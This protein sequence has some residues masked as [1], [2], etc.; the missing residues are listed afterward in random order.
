MK[1]EG[2]PSPAKKK[3]DFFVIILM[4]EPWKRGAKIHALSVVFAEA[5]WVEG[6]C[7]ESSSDSFDSSSSDS[8]PLSLSGALLSALY[9]RNSQR[10]KS[11]P[12]TTKISQ[13]GRGGGKVGITWWLQSFW[14]WAM[15]CRTY[16]V[17]PNVPWSP[18]ICSLSRMDTMPSCPNKFPFKSK[19]F[20][21]VEPSSAE[22]ILRAA[23]VEISLAD[24]ITSY[25]KKNTLEISLI[26]HIC[27][28]KHT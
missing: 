13:R 10:I 21:F 7:L 5:G 1:D 19:T 12:L 27:E 25:W 6:V 11:S 9:K 3:G 17:G 16:S 15:S 4:M 23:L 22:I 28:R 20:K 26:A 24:N 18:N 14:R 8:S 2:L